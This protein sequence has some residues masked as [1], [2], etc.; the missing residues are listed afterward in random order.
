MPPNQSVPEFPGLSKGHGA[1]AS[2]SCS[3]RNFAVVSTKSPWKLAQPLLARQPMRVVLVESLERDRLDGLASDLGG[4]L[5]IVGIGSGTAMD[6]AKYIAKKNGMLLSQVPTTCSNNACFTRTAGVQHGGR[7]VAERLAPVPDQIVVDYELM[8]R[9]P[10]RLNR[11]GLAEILCSHTSLKD[12]EL[13]R[14]AGIY[15][16]DENLERFTRGELRALEQLAPAIGSDDIDAFVALLDAGA[17]LAPFFISHPGVRFNGG[18]EH[19]FAWCLDECVG[20]RLIH[21]EAVSLGTVLMAY[22]QDNEPNWVIKIL[23]LSRVAF[24][25]DDIGVTWKQVEDTVMQLPEYAERAPKYY[26]YTSVNEFVSADNSGLAELAER[27]A[28][29]RESLIREVAR[30]SQGI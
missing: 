26:P 13:G 7:R 9:A 8:S 28:V 14:A 3:W 12:W 22:L 10:P 25:P 30:H 1:L 11:A 15:E 5:R 23:M 17:R 27:F 21:G 6:A 16:W 2:E 20:R 18:S 19:L 29:A 24:M 4:I